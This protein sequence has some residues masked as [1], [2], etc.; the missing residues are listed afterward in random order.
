[1]K[2]ISS[3]LWRTLSHAIW[4]FSRTVSKSQL[5]FCQLFWV[6]L[7]KIMYVHTY[8]CN[9]CVQE[10]EEEDM[11]AFTN[12]FKYVQLN[13]AVLYN[14]ICLY[15]CVFT[16]APLLYPKLAKKLLYSTQVFRAAFLYC[17]DI[18]VLCPIWPPPLSNRIKTASIPWWGIPY[19]IKINMSA[20]RAMVVC[21]Q[22]TQILVVSA[23][24]S[25]VFFGFFTLS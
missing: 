2:C 19:L 20:A 10:M 3:Q 15:I 9:V 4:L 18:Q 6:C 5:L 8:M 12:K 1:M 22:V 17:G 21:S 13:S 11:D 16:L 24:F 25:V 23:Q 14:I 7:K